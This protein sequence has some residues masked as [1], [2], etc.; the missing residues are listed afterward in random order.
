VS[1]LIAKA[2]EGGDAGCLPQAGTVLHDLSRLEQDAMQA[3]R[4]L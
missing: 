2:G 3:L 1:T 4:R